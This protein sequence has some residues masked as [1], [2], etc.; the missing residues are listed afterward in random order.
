MYSLSK[1]NIESF[2]RSSFDEKFEGE[3]LLFNTTFHLDLNAFF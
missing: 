1:T 3:F 2:F